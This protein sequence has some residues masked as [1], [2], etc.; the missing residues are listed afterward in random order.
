MEIGSY[1]P[2]IGSILFAD[3]ATPMKDSHTFTIGPLPSGAANVK[4]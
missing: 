4:Y 3:T 1:S 2:G